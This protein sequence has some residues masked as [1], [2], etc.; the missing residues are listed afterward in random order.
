MVDS[1][2][3]EASKLILSVGRTTAK[4]LLQWLYLKDDPDFVAMCA[5]RGQSIWRA[6]VYY[7]ADPVEDTPDTHVIKVK[8]LIR[9]L[10]AIG[11]FSPQQVGG[12]N[13]RA[14]MRVATWSW[15]Q[16]SEKEKAEGLRR[17]VAETR[18]A[19]YLLLDAAQRQERNDMNAAVL[20]LA[21]L[22]GVIPDGC[23]APSAFFLVNRMIAQKEAAQ[24]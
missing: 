16:I 21:M 20:K 9:E 11:E 1:E 24:E 17:A 4:R 15:S 22:S 7:V 10:I 6:K 14:F 12:L 13:Y 3:T 2:S 8:S 5:E 19:G 23:A 18:K